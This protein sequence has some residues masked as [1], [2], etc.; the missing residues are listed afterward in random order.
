[1]KYLLLA[2]LTLSQMASADKTTDA[3]KVNIRAAKFFNQ[4]FQD[5]NTLKAYESALANPNDKSFLHSFGLKPAVTNGLKAVPA[6][7]TLFLMK[8]GKVKWKARIVELNPLT[9]D[10]NGK[11]WKSNAK[12]LRGSWTS[13]QWIEDVLAYVLPGA[14]AEA[15]SGVGPSIE[16]KIKFLIATANTAPGIP[17]SN[18]LTSGMAVDGAANLGEAMKSALNEVQLGPKVYCDPL[19]AEM[20]VGKYQFRLT[21]D[22][23][24][25][26]SFIGK[27][28][29][30]CPIEDPLACLVPNETQKAH[31]NAISGELTALKELASKESYAWIVKTFSTENTSVTP[32]SV[33]AAIK[34]IDCGR[35][36]TAQWDDHSKALNLTGTQKQKI[37][38]WLATHKGDNMVRINQ[39]YDEM[40]ANGMVTATDA[41][42]KNA[43]GMK[44][45]LAGLATCCD[46][47]SCKTDAIQKLGLKDVGGQAPAESNQ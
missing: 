14:F 3:F 22:S 7:D 44:V 33:N 46:S 11:K 27:G 30:L 15:D 42:K 20:L 9:L 5:D 45:I 16:E 38:E 36:C 1:M 8:D 12:N 31:W 47:L 13:A 4:G 21:A 29:V 37:D 23:Q 17:D 39:I 18:K 35:T 32:A 19:Q 34:T 43:A 28:G 2:L 24:F 6:V 26:M 40:D 10:I 41:V 25:K